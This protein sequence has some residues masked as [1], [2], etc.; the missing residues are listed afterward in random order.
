MLTKVSAE[1][2]A[3]NPS[4]PFTTVASLQ[5]AG[6]LELSSAPFTPM[7]TATLVKVS[8]IASALPADRL[9]RPAPFST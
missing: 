7:N 8:T 3:P 2:V 9:V 5:S 6:V 1:S 4:V